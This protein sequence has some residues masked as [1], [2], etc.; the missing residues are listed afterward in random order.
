MGQGS[1][2]IVNNH[3]IGS[4]PRR[5]RAWATLLGATVGERLGSARSAG[6]RRL[7]IVAVPVASSACTIHSGSM[8]RRRSSNGSG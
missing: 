2:E 1:A 3:S 4:E 6:S 7:R 8:L 5:A